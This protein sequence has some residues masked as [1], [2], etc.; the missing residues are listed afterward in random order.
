MFQFSQNNADLHSADPGSSGCTNYVAS[1]DT[2]TAGRW[3]AVFGV[4]GA[5][6]SSLVA[7]WTKMATG[8]WHAPWLG[9]QANCRCA[10]TLR[11]QGCSAPLA[12]VSRGIS[13][14]GQPR[15]CYHAARSRHCCLH[16]ATATHSIRFSQ[17]RPNR[18]G[19]LA[20]CA[21]ARWHARSSVRRQRWSACWQSW[22]AKLAASA[23][24]APTYARSWR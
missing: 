10:E 6:T 7:S 13:V 11:R 3:F 24:P 4:V 18:P 17:R 9:C 21:I 23:P 8:P 1:C 5:P 14:C 16:Q 15:P 2:S 22:R 20:A 19:S 12:N